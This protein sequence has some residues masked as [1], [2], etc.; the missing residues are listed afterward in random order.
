VRDEVR[1][2]LLRDRFEKV[3][4]LEWWKSFQLAKEFGFF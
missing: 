2:V 3:V 1:C 4:E